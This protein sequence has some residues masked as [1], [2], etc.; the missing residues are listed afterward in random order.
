MG[1][2][3]RLGAD[4]VRA[5]AWVAEQRPRIQFVAPMASPGIRHVFEKKIAEV[6]N[7]PRIIVIDGQAQRVLAAADAVL[8]ASG[9]ATLETLLSRRPMVVAYRFG[10]ITAFVVRS[11]GLVKVANFSQPNLLIGRNLVPE[12]LQEQVTGPALGAAL[13]RVLDDPEFHAELEREFRTVHETLRCGGAD[14]AASAVLECV[15]GHA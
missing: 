15:R 3:D 14:R 2:V 5:A 4:F 11:L 13:L 1:E 6:P 10:A 8:V 7:A 9:T 12:F